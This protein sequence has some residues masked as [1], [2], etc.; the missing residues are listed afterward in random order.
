MP[1]QPTSYLCADGV[2]TIRALTSLDIGNNNIGE[3][4]LPKGWKL[5][6]KGGTTKGYQHTGGTWQEAAPEGA[7][8]EGVIALADAIKNNGALETIT[9]GDYKA[10]T[11]NT[12]MTKAD[13]S[14][15][16]LYTSGAII[17]AAFLPKCQ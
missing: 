17:V 4:V 6:Y 5:W 15:K 7:K 9:F 3:L 12:S 10:V 11:M 2:P 1:R 8:A 14:G 16:E 13:F